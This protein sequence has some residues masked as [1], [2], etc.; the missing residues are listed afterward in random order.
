MSLLSQ[1]LSHCSAPSRAQCGRLHWGDFLFSLP[2]ADNTTRGVDVN[3]KKRNDSPYEFSYGRTTRCT[4][5]QLMQ[6]LVLCGKQKTSSTTKQ[7]SEKLVELEKMFC[8]MSARVEE[9]R[10]CS[11]VFKLCA[12]LPVQCARSLWNEDWRYPER[13]GEGTFINLFHIH[14][15]E[16]SI[17]RIY[18][19]LQVL[20]TMNFISAKL[21][22]S[23]WLNCEVFV[24]FQVF[25]VFRI[26]KYQISSS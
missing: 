17:I 11:T 20:I 21:V 16:N 10:F 23:R 15:F 9:V 7:N 22:A 24:I 18:L 13:G 1:F 25:F 4:H 2:A 8:H 26:S 5:W 6:A 14:F 19:H 3:Q 12:L